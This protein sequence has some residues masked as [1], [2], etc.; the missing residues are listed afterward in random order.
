[1]LLVEGKVV[2]DNPLILRQLCRIEN[3]RELIHYMLVSVFKTIF[4]VMAGMN[5][6]FFLSSWKGVYS[7]CCV[8]ILGC[9]VVNLVSKVALSPDKWR[10]WNHRTS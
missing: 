8:H 10:S 6:L 4:S 5:V 2:A 1:M 3:V 7:W 9:V